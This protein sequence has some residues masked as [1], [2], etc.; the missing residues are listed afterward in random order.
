MIFLSL[1]TVTSDA[2]VLLHCRSI[3]CEVV[4]KMIV[5][6][7]NTNCSI[8]T[9]VFS[10]TWLSFSGSPFRHCCIYISLSSL[11][12]LNSWQ[13]HL[14]SIYLHPLLLHVIT[15][16]NF[17]SACVPLLYSLSDRQG[18]IALWGLVDFKCCTS[19]V[20][21]KYCIIASVWT[22]FPVQCIQYVCI[23][24]TC[25]LVH[26]STFGNI[27]SLLGVFGVT[28]HSFSDCRFYPIDI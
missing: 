22:H 26:S 10:E 25:V 23:Y 13:I 1:L 12:T 2:F 8:S 15:R 17:F 4:C 18:D 24:S 7:N 21:V 16:H 5:I 6:V 14:P 19:G 3:L 11:F 28:F 9:S 27:C 20:V